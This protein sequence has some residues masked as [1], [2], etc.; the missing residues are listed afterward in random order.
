MVG[1]KPSIRASSAP[2]YPA[3]YLHMWKS[4]NEE[5]VLQQ[6]FKELLKNPKCYSSFSQM[7]SYCTLFTLQK[8][9]SWI[10]NCFWPAYLSFFF[11][12]FLWFCTIFFSLFISF[13]F[14]ALPSVPLCGGW[15]RAWVCRSRPGLYPWYAGCGSVSW[16]L[17]ADQWRGF[18]TNRFRELWVVSSDAFGSKTIATTLVLISFLIPLC[19]PSLWSLLFHFSLFY[20]SVFGSPEN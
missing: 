4:K 9:F 2:V 16:D 11:F 18:L 10:K 13:S 14:S 5:F 19:V 6:L 3:L 20:L 17:C 12:S 1:K 15:K 7:K 8:L